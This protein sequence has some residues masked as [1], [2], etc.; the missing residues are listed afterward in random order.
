[1][2]GFRGPLYYAH[3]LDHDKS[4]VLEITLKTLLDSIENYR[5]SIV[6]YSGPT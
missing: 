3:S 1:M 2:S 5:P 4:Y 6:A